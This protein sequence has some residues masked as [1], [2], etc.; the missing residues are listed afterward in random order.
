MDTT[1]DKK[2]AELWL[3]ASQDKAMEMED[4]VHLVKNG[5]QQCEEEDYCASKRIC[6]DDA[7]RC[8]RSLFPNVSHYELYV[9]LRKKYLEGTAIEIMAK[10]NDGNQDQRK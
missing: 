1:T 2:D 5:F 6:G 3:N 8:V 7:C 4:L 9:S 10:D